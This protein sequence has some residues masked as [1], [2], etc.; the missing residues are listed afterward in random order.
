MLRVHL[1]DGRTLRFDLKSERQAAKWLNSARDHKFQSEITGITI[2]HGGVSYS[3]SRP[4]GCGD[5]FLFA[6]YLVKNTAQKFKGGGRVVC[7]A[8]D[9]RISL[10][11]HEAQR[12]AHVS[13]SKTGQQCYNPII[14]ARRD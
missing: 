4:R 9:T 6:E 7:Q 14:G 12:A 10:M 2:K 5:V 13:V 11:V 3:L 1:T 8:D